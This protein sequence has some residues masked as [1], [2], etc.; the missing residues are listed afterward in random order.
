MTIARF[1]ATRLRLGGHG[2]VVRLAREGIRRATGRRWAAA[3]RAALYDPACFR[4]ASPLAPGFGVETGL[5]IDLLPR[6]RWWKWK[7]RWSTVPPAP[8][9]APNCTGPPVRRR[10]PRSRSGSCAAYGRGERADL[11]GRIANEQVQRAE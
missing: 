8:I 10:G 5:T 9:S 3:Q 6:S 2:M 4:R 1:P 7:C 11:L